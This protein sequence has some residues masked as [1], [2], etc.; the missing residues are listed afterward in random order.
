MDRAQGQARRKWRLDPWLTV[1]YIVLCLIGIVMVYSASAAV[2]LQ[3]GGSAT[4]Y[5]I[6]QAIFVIV[7]FAVAFAMARIPLAKL[8]NGRFL[9]AFFALLFAALVWVRA[10]GASVNGAHGWIPLGPL[11]IQPAEIVKFFIILYLARQFDSF[12][13]RPELSNPVHAIKPF[14]IVGILLLLILIQPD[15]G[16]F[17]INAMIAVV[18]FLGGE[19]NWRTGARI[20]VG[21]VALLIVGLPFAARFIAAHMHSY[22][23][24]RFVAYIDPFSA[25]RGVGNQLVNSY[26]AISNGGL[27]GVGLGNSIQKMGYLPEPNTDF[28]LAII[29]EELG[30]VMVI[31]ILLLLAIIVCRTIVVGIRADTLYKTLICY[32]V[33]TFFA[34][35]TFFNIGGVCGLLPI[36]GVTL[37]FISYGGSSMVVLSA[38]LGLVLNISRQLPARKG[39]IHG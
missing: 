6:K 30:L 8:K 15:T 21:G 34:V 16:G 22:Q 33:A 14:I 25:T 3:N 28:I 9:L 18:M 24:S 35:E 10:W 2:T 37:P 31:I 13:A 12:Q 4:S 19:I 5:L 27:T 7:G 38:A 32:G 29:A 11:S 39:G 20:I 17:A 26:Y 36:T 1:P 23:A